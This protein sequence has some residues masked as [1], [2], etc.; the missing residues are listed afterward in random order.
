M[1][2]LLCAHESLMWRAVNRP[3]P[4]VHVAPKDGF[5]V[6][7]CYRAKGNY[8]AAYRQAESALLRM[9]AGDAYVRSVLT[10]CIVHI[11]ATARVLTSW[12]RLSWKYV[13]TRMGCD[14]HVGMCRCVV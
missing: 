8:V 13:A 11:H 6:D 10:E 12:K 9:H 3:H 7:A 14:A 4:W 5:L 1:R 2:E